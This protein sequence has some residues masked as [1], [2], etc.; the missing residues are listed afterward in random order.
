MRD[1]ENFAHMLNAESFLINLAKNEIIPI[2]TLSTAQHGLIKKLIPKFEQFP[3]EIYQSLNFENGNLL[4]VKVSETV[5]VGFIFDFTQFSNSQSQL[6][7]IYV[8]T[9]LT[10]ISQIIFRLYTAKKAPQAIVFIHNYP[11]NQ[12]QIIAEPARLPDSHTYYH[13]ETDIIKAIVYSNQTDLSIAL[14]KL[15]QIDFFNVLNE[16]GPSLRQ[17]KNFVISYIAVLTRAINQWGFP[18]N[19]AFKIQS[20]LVAEVEKTTQFP[21]F[22]NTIRGLAWFFFKTIKSYRINNLLP[23]ALRIKSYID[24]HVCDNIV[25]S[26]IALAMHT[27]KKNLN[28]AF[29]AEFGITIIQFIRTRK[30]ERAKEMLL[31]SDITIPEIA[32]NLSFSTP[33]YFIQTFKSLTG[34]TPNYFRSNYFCKNNN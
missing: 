26:D 24:E 5:K 6:S 18:I 32:A 1:I 10:P 9:K 33:S 31:I 8:L 30:I 13:I 23:L 7:L 22:M 20:N 3:D 25:L 29:K 27:S 34:M 17:K 11:F 14:E 19:H 16:Q 15:P 28:P 4:S 21:D 2:T 12:R